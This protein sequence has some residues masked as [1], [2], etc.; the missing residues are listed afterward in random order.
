[1]IF[2]LLFFSNTLI[3]DRFMAKWEVKPINNVELD[4]N[5]V[6]ILLTGMSTYSPLIDRIQFNDRT[7]RLMQTIDL[8]H[9][10]KIRNLILCGG[11]STLNSS[12]AKDFTML[13]E[14]LVQN[15]IPDSIIVDEFASR[16]TY[17]NAINCKNL[18]SHYFPN[19]KPILIT[20]GYHM[21]R[22][23]ACFYK[24]GIETIPFSTDLYSGPLK[25]EL[26]YLLLP[27]AQT[28][29][30]W[31]KILHEWFGVVVYQVTGKV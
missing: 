27:S 18:I 20:S 1:M 3:F 8:Y 2:I 31:E 21:R 10:G 19:T 5:N 6:A 9:K 11:S 13:H 29:M 14:Y 7:D 24:Q 25:F 4:S 15:G 12:E 30:N 17:E 23:M 28:M 26:D 22:A 16:N